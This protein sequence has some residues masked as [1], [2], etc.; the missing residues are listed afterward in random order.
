MRI[1]SPSWLNWAKRYWGNQINQTEHSELIWSKS[2]QL[3]LSTKVFFLIE[4]KMYILQRWRNRTGKLN[5]KLHKMRFLYRN[6]AKTEE[7][8]ALSSGASR[9]VVMK[10]A[11]TNFPLSI[12]SAILDGTF[13]YSKV[14]EKPIWKLL[15]NQIQDEKGETMK[16]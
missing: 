5:R 1:E 9:S 11:D 13:C 12:A 7:I 15:F 4:W 10:W 3:Q 14:S 8:F 16:A 6:D 2:Y